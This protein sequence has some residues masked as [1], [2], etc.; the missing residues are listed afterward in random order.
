[1]AIKAD[2][3]QAFDRMEWSFILRV[4]RCY[5]FSEHWIHQCLSSVS[6]SILLNGSPFGLISPTWGLRQGD[7]LSP[8]LFILGTEVLSRMFSRAER[9]RCIHGTKISRSTTPISHLLF[10]DD[11]MIF[12]RATVNEAAVISNL[13][14]IYAGWS[15]QELNL[16]KSSVTFSRNVQQALTSSLADSLGISQSDHPG[17]YLGLPLVIP[18]SKRQAHLVL[19]E[20]VLKRVF[21]WKSKLL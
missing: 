16:N 6:Y 21:G 18:R 5:G 7:P 10:A 9:M 4:L 11:T 14:D 13:L 15:G 12:S 20:R 3:A 1:M 17:T 2:M 8:F 19:K